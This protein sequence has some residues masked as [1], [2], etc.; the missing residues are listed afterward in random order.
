MGSAP[1]SAKTAHSGMGPISPFAAMSA[2][3]DD[4]TPAPRLRICM[5]VTL[6]RQSLGYSLGWWG[7]AFITVA[8]VLFAFTS[9]IYN[10]YLGENTLNYFS[11]S[12][13][14]LF[15]ALRFTTLVLIIWGAN[16]DLA[17]VFGFAD[18]TMGL[19]ALVNLAALVMLMP[20][21]L[22][23]L[24]DYERQRQA[25]VKPSF[26]ADDHAHLRLDPLSWPAQP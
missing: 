6:T 3:V 24:N 20:M 26:S 4:W 15:T 13:Q 10:Y 18:L 9:I 12:N 22:R 17:T 8:L 16:Q 21:G 11:D 14:T 5:G 23:V 7:Q 19:L 1:V 2:T 25:G